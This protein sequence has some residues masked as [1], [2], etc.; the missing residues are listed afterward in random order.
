MQEVKV[1]AIFGASNGP[2]GTARG[3]IQLRYMLEVLNVLVIPQ[4][5][6]Y[7]RNAAEAFHP[8]GSFK[9]PQTTA[10]LKRLM[11]RTLLVARQLTSNGSV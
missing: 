1:L 7:I 3:Q 2:Y 10:L 5:M 8:A 4:P 9:A 11:E 6:I